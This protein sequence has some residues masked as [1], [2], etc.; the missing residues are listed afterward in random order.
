M[1]NLRHYEGTEGDTES[2]VYSADCKSKIKID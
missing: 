1:N 2:L